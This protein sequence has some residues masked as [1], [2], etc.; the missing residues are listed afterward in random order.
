MKAQL[1]RNSEIEQKDLFKAIL[2]LKTPSE[3]ERFLKDLL[4]PSELHSFSFRWK[5]AKLLDKDMPYRKI[6]QQTGVSTAT[7]TRIA[8]AL[9]YGDSG[10][11]RVLDRFKEKTK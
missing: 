3:C 6:Q 1:D 11:R 7:I 8:R 9:V 2:S 5:V 10:Y 4:T